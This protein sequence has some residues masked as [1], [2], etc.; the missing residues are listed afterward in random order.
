MVETT[1]K[2]KSKKIKSIITIVILLVL[3]FLFAKMYYKKGIGPVSL[4]NP[5]EVSFEIPLGSS[6]SKVG[7]ILKNNGLI[8]SQ[9][10]F[11]NVVNKEGLSDKLKAGQYTLNTSMD[12]YE[13]VQH[14]SKGGSNTNVVKITIP[15]GFE[16][17]QIS[18]RLSENNI[19]DE[20]VFNS[21]ISDA[22][23]FKDKYEFLQE[24]P[25]NSTLEGYLFPSTYEI[26][27][28]ASEKVIIEMMLNKF[29]E[30][31][32]TRIKGQFEESG[33]SL[34]ELIT[35][36]SIV[37]REG[38]VDEERALI[39]AVFYNRL[40]KGMLL[41]SCATVQYALGE[42]KEKLSFDDLK[43]K[44]D[45]NTY[46]NKGLPPGPIASPG[47]SSIEAAIK[48]EEGVDYLFFVSNGDGTHTFTTN[49]KD[50]INA[51]NKH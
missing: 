31:Y 11:K 28:G 9:I 10:V 3:L 46:T 7:E 21:L 27:K 33:L 49:F 47:L 41:E 14:L 35:L 36:A 13:I 18:K 12:I 6:T 8:N 16:L 23:N 34:N 19:V 30:V 29:Q 4:D 2:K 26:E 39:A 40:D 32:E 45:Y 22:N 37:E 17:K 50:H 20:E 51:K 15:E 25:P 44:S 42:R 38:K 5:V 48:P 43:I 24:L 1:K